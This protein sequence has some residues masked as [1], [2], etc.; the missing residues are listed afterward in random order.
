[1]LLYKI[2]GVQLYKWSAGALKSM[3]ITQIAIMYREKNR[4]TIIKNLRTQMKA[5]NQCE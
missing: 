1:M 3:I 4:A 2:A 5:S